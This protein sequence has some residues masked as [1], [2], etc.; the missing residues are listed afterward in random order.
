MIKNQVSCFFRHSVVLTPLPRRLS[1]H[2]T[3]LSEGIAHC[4]VSVGRRQL[5]IASLHCTIGHS[6]EKIKR[7]CRSA[8]SAP[9]TNTDQTGVRYLA[10]KNR[11]AYRYWAAFQDYV[12]Y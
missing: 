2:D 4:L 3:V 11:Q 12:L 5:S 1:G 10:D 8:S 7:H 9:K 6:A